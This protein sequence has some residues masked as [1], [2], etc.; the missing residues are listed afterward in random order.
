MN[1]KS[2]CFI[3]GRLGLESG[4]APRL[5]Y[6]TFIIFCPPTSSL[7]INGIYLGYNVELDRIHPDE[8]SYFPITAI[9]KMTAPPDVAI[10]LR[11]EEMAL[12]EKKVRWCLGSFIQSISPLFFFGC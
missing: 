7:L 1:R 5:M 6:N 11:I 4:R 10:P 2:Q 12:P 9:S 3:E 8:Q